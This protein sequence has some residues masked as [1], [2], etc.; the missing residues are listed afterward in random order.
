MELSDFSWPVNIGKLQYML[1]FLVW[2]VSI[3]A[4]RSTRPTK[5]ER[6]L[7]LAYWNAEVTCWLTHNA[8]IMIDQLHQKSLT[9]LLHQKYISWYDSEQVPSH[10]ADDDTIGASVVPDGKRR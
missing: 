6:N 4:W 5:L 2:R 1:N 3:T 8:K 7:V 9:L 10:S